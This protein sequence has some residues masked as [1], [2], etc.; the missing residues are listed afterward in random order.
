M[1]SSGHGVGGSELLWTSQGWDEEWRELMCLKSSSST[2]PS[3]YALEGGGA[4]LVILKK[5]RLGLGWGECS[6]LP[7]PPG[8]SSLPEGSQGTPIIYLDKT[9]AAVEITS[10]SNNPL[11]SFINPISL[12]FSLS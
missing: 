10:P 2:V 3:S 8:Q 1:L 7:R 12:C 4:G 11:P 6:L 5:K 9:P